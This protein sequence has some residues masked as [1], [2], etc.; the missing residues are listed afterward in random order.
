MALFIGVR[1]PPPL[2]WLGVGAWVSEA[3]TR[4]GGMPTL[5]LVP[6]IVTT[7][8]EI[9]QAYGGSPYSG[10]IVPAVRSKKV[11]VFS[12]PSAGEQHGYTFD[13]QADDDE[14]GTLYLYTGA[15]A[16]GDQQLTGGNRSLLL[17]AQQGRDV[18]LFVAD[19]LVPGTTT[20]RQRYIGQ[21]VVDPVEPYEV[22]WSAANSATPRQIIVFRLRAAAGAQP[23][24]TDADTIRPATETTVINVP[25]VSR[26]DTT[27]GVDEVPPEEHATDETTAQIQAG[28]RTIVRREGK[29]V[30]AFKEHLEAAGH[31]ITA[32]ALRVK[33]VRSPLRTDLYDITDNVLYEAKGLSQRNHVRLAIGQLLDYRRHLDTPPGLRL[34]VLLPSD[35][36]DDLRDLLATEGISLVFQTEDGFEGFPLALGD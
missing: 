17:H 18:H 5:E 32:H 19:G 12:D 28:I 1:G 33:G 36:G 22:Q 26:V 31:G 7:R 9:A 15:G 16:S 2:F 24:L 11:F 29:L 23:A 34:A 13:G 30:T 8:A 6:G 35:P 3:A 21:V 4:F 27:V 10:G 20:R 25:V 14:F